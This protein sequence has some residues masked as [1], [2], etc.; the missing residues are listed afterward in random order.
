[1]AYSPT[2]FAVFLDNRCLT[3]ATISLHGPVPQWLEIGGTASW[4]RQYVLDDVRLYGRALG[5]AEIQSLYNEDSDGDGIP[6]CQD[7]DYAPPQDGTGYGRLGPVE[8]TGICADQCG[9]D[10]CSLYQWLHKHLYD[11]FYNYKWGGNQK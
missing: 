11:Y 7:P 2:N 1:M 8:D 10:G 4:G 5:L 9:E 6:N 3:N